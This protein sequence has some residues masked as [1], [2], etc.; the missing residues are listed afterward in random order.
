MEVSRAI[1][2]TPFAHT[3]SA[4]SREDFQSQVEG[5]I[6][7]VSDTYWQLV[8]AREQLEVAEESLDLAK[9]LHEMNKIQ[10]EVGTMAPLETVQSEAGVATREEDI[11]RRQAAVE[12]SRLIRVNP[13]KGAE[14]F[15]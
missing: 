12:D 8:E 9:D 4:I 15:G 10:V 7:Q 3:N 14:A 2:R 5:I 13:G 1:T 6:Q 11:I